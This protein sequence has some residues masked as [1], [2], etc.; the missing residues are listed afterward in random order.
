LLC[1]LV[2]RDQAAREFL[3]EQDWKEVLSQT[4]DTELLIRILDHDLRPNDPASLSA[5]MATL[6][7]AEESLI[8]S[9][10]LQ[11]IPGDPVRVAEGWWRG[12]LLAAL[13]RQLEAAESRMKLPKLST[14]EEVNLQKQVVDLKGRLSELSQLSPTPPT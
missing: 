9:W 3:K 13:R 14:G 11:R 2:L 4:P 5:F 10:L 8:A 7:P 1:L 12:L 6:T